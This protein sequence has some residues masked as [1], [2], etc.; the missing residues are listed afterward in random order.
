MGVAAPEPSP[1]GR[2]VASGWPSSSSPKPA[3]RSSPTEFVAFCVWPELHAGRGLDIHEE[4]DRSG[5]PR[6]GLVVSSGP[7]GSASSM[8]LLCAAKS[9]SKLRFS[10][11]LL[12]F[13][14]CLF[15]VC[16]LTA[17]LSGSAIVLSIRFRMS[18]SSCRVAHNSFCS[19]STADRRPTTSSVREGTSGKVQKS[20]DPLCK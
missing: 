9:C 5:V 12:A 1:G 13:C 3:L 4:H 10:A 19:S 15:S 18:A 20:R 11:A 17:L 6:L 14:L 7:W 16:L 2:A 8:S